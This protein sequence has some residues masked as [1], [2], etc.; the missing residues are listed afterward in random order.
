VHERYRTLGAM[1]ALGDFSVAE[2]ATLAQVG[3]S[4]VRTVLRREDDYVERV[5]P[6][7]TGRRGGQPVRWRLRTDAR[8]SIRAILQ[9]LENLGAGSWLDDPSAPA[10]PE[11]AVLAAEDTLLRLV[12]AASDPDERAEL[13]KLARAQ[14]ET[15][16][17]AVAPEGAGAS[18]D[19]LRVV[20][21]LL[22]LAEDAVRR[23]IP[24]SLYAKNF[25]ISHKKPDY[26]QPTQ[27][28]PT[29]ERDLPD[30]NVFVE[31]GQDRLFGTDGVRGIAGQDLTAALAVDLAI[32]AAQVLARKPGA[33]P[34]RATAVIGRDSS[35]SG[36]FLESAIIAGLTS[37]GVDVIQI[38]VAPAAA[39]AFLT[40]RHD[41]QLGVSLSASHSKAPYNGIK[42]FGQGGYKLQ[43]SVEDQIERQLKKAREHKSPGAV[44]VVFGT[45]SDGSGEIESY[46]AHVLSAALPDGAAKALA[47]LHVVVDCA[48]GAASAI[49]PR[50]LREAG[51]EVTAIGVSP[52]GQN[53]NIGSGSTDPA[54]LIAEV[55]R[56]NAN[57]G[58]A[59]DGDGDACMA[60]DHRGRLVDGDKILAALAVDLADQ[61]KLTHRTV[62]MTVMSNLGFRLAMQ[63]ADIKVV[64]TQVGDRYLADEIRRGDY[65]LGGTQSG[66]IIIADHA[67]GPDGLLVSLCLLAIV[68]RSGKTL[69]E[70][71]DVMTRH[72]QVLV[73]V[74]I[75]EDEERTLI[76][77]SGQ[78]V[79]AVEEAA[80]E[81]GQRGRIVL[82]PSGTEPVVRV[83]VED[84]DRGQAE[85]LA[86][87]LADTVLE[88]RQSTAV[89]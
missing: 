58:I 80:E 22:E 86:H 6:Q 87:Q 73:N 63:A 19:S 72:P 51:V 29:T 41:A 4:T 57:A 82:R 69:A 17:A 76:A 33:G 45:V 67:T 70:V 28:Y 77:N 85:R 8:E 52:D 64:E 24:V 16:E 1:L 60:V 84:D 68:A 56:L 88:L 53:I 39:V 61:G 65:S 14:V 81:L 18:S 15:A 44:P 48:N 32:A 49:A 36:Q 23:R 66:R 83:M 43:D 71:T 40:E 7:P 34:E 26:P 20:R 46:I 47:G 9:R 13:I 75:P 31:A 2:I 35:S 38:G 27:S 55:N 79:N 78:L 74:R 89:H 50:L 11:A 30:G 21:S 12:P 25:F 59:Y 54:A 62:V 37:S 5:G 10:G 42:F 3:E